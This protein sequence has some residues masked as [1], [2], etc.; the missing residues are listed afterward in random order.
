MKLFVDT[1]VWSMALRRDAPAETPE[2]TRLGLGLS[3]QESA[4][5]IGLILQE[6]FQGPHG[7]DDP[8]PIQ[9]TQRPQGLGAPARQKIRLCEET[10][11]SGASSRR[12]GAR[13]GSLALF[14][15]RPPELVVW[16]REP[17]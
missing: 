5:T 8:L 11:A 2:V 9:E 17:A 6:L 10:R 3:S 4:F 1:S 12:G 13:A 15:A 14:E 16:R 7:R